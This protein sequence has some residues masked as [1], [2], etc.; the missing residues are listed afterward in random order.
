MLSPAEKKR[1]LALHREIHLAR[2]EKQKQT[3]KDRAVKKDRPEAAYTQGRT[4]GGGGG[5]SA[6]KQHPLSQT[7]QFSGIDR[8][9]VSIPAE[10]TAETNQEQRQELENRYQHRLGLGYQHAKKI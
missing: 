9:V 1:L 10:N 4:Y 2:V 7:A 6:Y 3:R 8:Q 5:S